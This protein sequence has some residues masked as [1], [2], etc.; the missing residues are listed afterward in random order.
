MLSPNQQAMLLRLVAD[1]GEHEFR[2][3]VGH[4]A[5]KIDI[6]DMEQKELLPSGRHLSDNQVGWARIHPTSKPY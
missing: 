6:P 3:G 2:D 5:L 4:L 1:G